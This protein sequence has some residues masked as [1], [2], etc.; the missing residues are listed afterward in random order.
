MPL[1]DFFL[2]VR[3]PP[4]F[5]RFRFR[6]SDS[7]SLEGRKERRKEG[8]KEGRRDGGREG[9]KEVEKEGQRQTDRHLI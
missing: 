6:P 9:G 2:S 7:F 4:S 3:L 5:L 1:V 8:R